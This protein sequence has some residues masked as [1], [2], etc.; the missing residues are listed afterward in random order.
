MLKET[1]L[2]VFSFLTGEELYHKV[3]LL[4]KKT[5]ESLPD[6]HLLNQI[7]ILTMRNA[8]IGS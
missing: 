4:N 2:I 8:N 1:K 5:R 6:S 3:A 7:K